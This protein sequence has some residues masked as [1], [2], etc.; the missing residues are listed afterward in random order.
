MYTRP[1]H[2]KK[3]VPEFKM[4]EK[5]LGERWHE[6]VERENPLLAFCVLALGMLVIFAFVVVLGSQQAYGDQLAAAHKATLTTSDKLAEKDKYT[7]HIAKLRSMYSK[8]LLK[9]EKKALVKLIVA[10][11]DGSYA[12]ARS[13]SKRAD[14]L[15][16]RP[17]AVKKRKAKLVSTLS[18]EYRELKTHLDGGQRSRVISAISSIKGDR[19][20]G[21][22]TEHE[23]SAQTVFQVGR[24]RVAYGGDGWDEAKLYY[25]AEWAP[26]IDSY[27]SGTPMAGTG[28]M[29]SRVAY[30][31]DMDARLYPAIARVESGCGAAPYGCA[32]NVCGWVWNP[33]AMYSWED[34]CVKWHSYFGQWFG[35][36]RYPISSMHGYGGYGP[37]YVNDQMARI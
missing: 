30:D 10:A 17:K 31:H 34:A 9:T 37:S 14:K 15:V 13:C 28:A 27:L 36:E 2:A 7:A 4:P 33:P 16:V 5:T 3:H 19:T 24:L 32:Y 25:V 12:E 29:I 21:Q 18:S 26:R 35:G 20:D 23:G 22:L 11:A 8:E 6:E 1:D